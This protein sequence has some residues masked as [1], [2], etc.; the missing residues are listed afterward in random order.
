M[1][2]NLLCGSESLEEDEE[3][4][5]YGTL[6]VKKSLNISSVRQGMV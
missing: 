3:D 4:A 5:V 2:S 1:Q 6:L